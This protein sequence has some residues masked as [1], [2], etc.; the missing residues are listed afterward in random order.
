MVYVY[1]GAGAVLL[2]ILLLLVYIWRKKHEKAALQAKIDK[3][4]GEASDSLLHP[5]FVFNAMSS[6][7]RFMNEQNTAAA[8]RYLSDFGKLI[9]L[10]MSMSS[11]SHISLEEELQF[12]EIYLLFEQLRFDDAI[13]FT[14]DVEPS[15]DFDETLIPVNIIRPFIENL[16]WYSLL[17]VKK[18]G[19]IHLKIRKNGEDQLYVELLDN[20]KGLLSVYNKENKWVVSE[21]IDMMAKKLDALGK[22]KGMQPLL[23]IV[24]QLPGTSVPGTKIS[25]YLPV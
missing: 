12:I 23:E 10:N 9:R 3:L 14:V 11:K 22:R 13:I 5:H 21:Q 15:I 1:I 24:E 6:I 8:N 20:G 2:T 25:F 19:E 7:Q 17:S 4:E 16:I 18:Q